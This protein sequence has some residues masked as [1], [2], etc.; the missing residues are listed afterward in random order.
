MDQNRYISA[1]VKQPPNIP[2]SNN[3]RLQ[4]WKYHNEGILKKYQAKL[5]VGSLDSKPK[6]QREAAPPT[7]PAS[8]PPVEKDIAVVKPSAEP[9]T[10]APMP[11]PAAV[12]LA[13]ALEQY[14][15]MIPYADPAWYQT[16]SLLEI[17]AKLLKANMFVKVPFA[18]LQPNTCRPTQ[19]SA[20]LG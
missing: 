8:P 12:E 10:V 19:R 5:K 18:L 14:G 15:D 1:P 9:G 4:F 13:D 16:V 3:K 7:P 11:G 2:C 20:N 17:F 6:E